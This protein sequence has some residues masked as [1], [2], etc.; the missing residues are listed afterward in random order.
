MSPST[1]QLIE[2]LLEMA[3]C[4]QEVEGHVRHEADEFHATCIYAAERLRLLQEGHFTDAA[5]AAVA[6]AREVQD[7]RRRLAAIRALPDTLLGAAD[8]L[9]GDG[10]KDGWAEAMRQVKALLDGES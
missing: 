6:L 3:E 8:T 1:D 5:N 2:E 7:S 4:T 10:V 9:Y